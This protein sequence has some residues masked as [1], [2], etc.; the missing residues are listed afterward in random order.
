MGRAGSTLAERYERLA[1]QTFVAQVVYH[2][3][4]GS[5]N[6][7]ARLHAAQADRLP[8]LVIAAQQTAGRGRQAR[9]WWSDAGSLTFS[10]LLGPDQV[11]TGPTGSPLISLL[12]A[13]AVM[14]AVGPQVG[15]IP[16]GLH[17][18]NDV[19]L[20][21]RKLSGVLV[22]RTAGGRLIVGVGLNV[23][24]RFDEAPAEVARRAT[25]LGAATGKE[26]DLPE[27]LQ[28]YLR[29]LEQRLT[30]LAADPAAIARDAHDACLQRGH[31]VSIRIGNRQVTGGCLGIDAEGALLLETPEGPRAFATGTMHCEDC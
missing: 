8:L 30:Q 31:V 18:P 14:E 10:L 15:T 21:G 9:S 22:E 5:T 2:D 28:D 1:G 3:V 24:T 25:S 29:A 16:L 4:L 19:Y 17:W 7:Q 13:L 11:A 12:P 6:D 27:V 20:D 23:N 26:F